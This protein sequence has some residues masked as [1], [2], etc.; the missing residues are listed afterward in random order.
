M[1]SDSSG[2]GPFVLYAAC[3]E[4]E[5]MLVSVD[6][7]KQQMEVP[8]DGDKHEIRDIQK[9]A[10]AGGVKIEISSDKKSGLWQLQLIGSD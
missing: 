3:T 5:K 6:Q 1:A 9:I 4:N 8:C 10:I 7:G 2:Q